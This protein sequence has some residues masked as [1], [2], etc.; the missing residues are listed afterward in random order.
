M[1]INR[2]F[3]PLIPWVCTFYISTFG[4]CFPVEWIL[5]AAYCFLP[6]L[7][8][9]FFW[10]GFATFPDPPKDGVYPNMSLPVTDANL[11]LYAQ[12]MVANIK[13]RAAWFQTGEVLWPWVSACSVFAVEETGTHQ[14]VR[15]GYLLQQVLQKCWYKPRDMKC[16][17]NN[18]GPDDWLVMIFKM[19][20]YSLPVVYQ[21]FHPTQYRKRS[22]ET[23]CITI[24]CN[25]T[26]F[27][28]PLLLCI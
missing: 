20:L 15:G 9:G 23:S 17:S 2:R 6:P 18:C 7:R 4:V 3:L 5:F 19:S 14:S 21:V 8:S 12:T 11:H 16:F 25:I 26:S 10:N 1:N 28:H 24:Y 22:D 27:C 13:E